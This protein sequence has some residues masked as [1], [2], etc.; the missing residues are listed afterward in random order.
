MDA[1]HPVSSDQLAKRIRD[2]KEVTKIQCTDGNWN[3]DPYM[4]GLANGLIMA[5]ALLEAKEPRFFSRP[6]NWL[7]N[8]YEKMAQAMVACKKRISNQRVLHYYVQACLHGKK[9]KV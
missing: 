5:V 1:E 3:Y 8:N 2:I 4:Q 9:T 7:H 6:K